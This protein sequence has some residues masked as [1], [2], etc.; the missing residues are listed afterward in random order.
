MI[1]RRDATLSLLANFCSMEEV[2]HQQQAS[3][4][5]PANIIMNGDSVV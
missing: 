1:E 2:D 4:R 3:D 5:H